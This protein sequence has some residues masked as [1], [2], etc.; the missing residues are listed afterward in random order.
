MNYQVTDGPHNYV[1]KK[2]HEQIVEKKDAE[3]ARLT[4]DR[5]ANWQ[6]AI[7]ELIAARKEIERLEDNAAFWKSEAA[8]WQ[9][10]A[11]ECEREYEI[12]PNIAR[13]TSRIAEL[14]K[15]R[16]ANLPAEEPTR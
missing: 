14:E 11:H 6:G 4:S 1:H 12:E 13:L 10:L 3:I 2:F 15:E 9:R 7:T 16:D 8:N 5:N